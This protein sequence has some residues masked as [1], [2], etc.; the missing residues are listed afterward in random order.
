VKK[1][2]QSVSQAECGFVQNKNAQTGLEIGERKINGFFGLLGHRYA[3]ES[4][5]GMAFHEIREYFPLVAQPVV[6]FPFQVFGYFLPKV[7]IKAG[8][9]TLA[10]HHAGGQDPDGNGQGFFLGF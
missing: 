3:R 1:G 7:N 9:S 5:I 2:F 6:E 8:I 4:N 10:F